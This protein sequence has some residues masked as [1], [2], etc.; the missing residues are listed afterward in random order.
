MMRKLNLIWKIL[1]ND[2][3]TTIGVKEY[4]PYKL[5]NYEENEEKLDKIIN[6]VLNKI[7]KTNEFVSGYFN[8]I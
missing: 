3:T 7:A 1:I 5:L 6:M 2:D 8:N 4:K